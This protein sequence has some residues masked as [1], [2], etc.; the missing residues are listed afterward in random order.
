ML[1]RE[2]KYAR[3]PH[4]LDR[5]PQITSEMRSILLDW[6][7]QVCQELGFLRLTFHLSVDILDRFLGQISNFRRDKLQVNFYNRV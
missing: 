7:M 4:F 1:K 3:N 5:H 2:A 6:M